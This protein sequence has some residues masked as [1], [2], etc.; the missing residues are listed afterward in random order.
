MGRLYGLAY[1]VITL[2]SKIIPVLLVILLIGT[3]F[4]FFKKNLPIIVNA[5]QDIKIEKKI[6][7]YSAANTPIE[8]YQIGDGQE[9]LLF[10]GAIHGHEKGT[11]D[12]LGKL[13]EEL[14]LSPALVPKNKKIVIIPIVN[15]DGYAKGIDILN[16]N[17]VN[18]NLNFDTSGWQPYG[19]E[20]T[21][22]GKEP[23]QSQ[24]VR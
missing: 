15:P 1:M 10:F 3:Y 12:L 24:K 4:V 19:K 14:R 18:L 11:G 2:K 20:G 21:F 16:A 17:G 5:P 6:F 9:V 13:V 23:F 7:G 22:A 8:G